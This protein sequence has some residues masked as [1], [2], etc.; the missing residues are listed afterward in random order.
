MVSKGLLER[1]ILEYHDEKNYAYIEAFGKKF[2]L[3]LIPN[4]T[5][6]DAANFGRN[7]SMGFLN[8][9]KLERTYD[10]TKSDIHLAN[11]T[12]SLETAGIYLIGNKK[13]REFGAN[14]VDWWL[15]YRQKNWEGVEKGLRKECAILMD[16]NP[17]NK[18]VTSAVYYMLKAC[19]KGHD[20]NNWDVCEKYFDKAYA[21]ISMYI[22]ETIIS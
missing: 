6:E 15:A 2:A 10:P 9:D 19:T 18:E 1:K 14:K 11:L 20:K 5:K 13:G 4:I 21:I 3:A 12:H 7:Y 16:A 17:E 8:A 22:P